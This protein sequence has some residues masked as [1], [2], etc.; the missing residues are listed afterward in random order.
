MVVPTSARLRR[1]G[2]TESAR[3]GL[4]R[5]DRVDRS[6]APG[7]IMHTR[8][9]SHVAATLASALLAASVVSC[10]DSDIVGVRSGPATIDM[11][12]CPGS[13]PIYFAVQDDGGDWR[14]IP[15]PSSGHLSFETTERFGMAWTQ[16]DYLRTYVVYATAS[17]VSPFNMVCTNPFGT[18]VVTGSLAGDGFAA[19]VSMAGVSYYF[20]VPGDFSLFGIP[21]GPQDVV[22]QLYVLNGSEVVPKSMLIQRGANVPNYGALPLLDFATATPLAINTLTVNNLTPGDFNAAETYFRTSGGTDHIVFGTSLAGPTTSLPLYGAPAS[23]T[24]PGDLHRVEVSGVT[25]DGFAARYAWQFYRT[26]ADQSITLGPALSRPTSSEIISGD[27]TQLR[28]RVSFPS[29]IEY[30]SLGRVVFAQQGAHIVYY[31]VAATS[32]YIGQRPP[33]WTL[34]IPDLSGA[35]FPVTASLQKGVPTYEILEAWDAPFSTVFAGTS[36]E[37]ESVHYAQLVVPPNETFAAFD[38]DFRPP[39]LRRARVNGSLAAPIRR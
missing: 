3:N 1:P 27:D 37:G 32:A 20:N 23:L 22:A 13:V 15:V 17:E 31:F 18:K 28:L 14:R 10:D 21:E 36:T 24:Q 34:E 26:P 7:R 2:G 9:A 6:L 16:V 33:E 4:R 30:G 19:G 5:A 8:V 29:Q 38:R 39:G 12:F 25:A 11:T 35:E